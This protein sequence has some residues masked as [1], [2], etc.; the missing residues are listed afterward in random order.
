MQDTGCRIQ[1]ANP[2]CAFSGGRARSSVLGIRPS[3]L[4]RSRVPGARYP[5]PGTRYQALVFKK[6]AH[7]VC[8]M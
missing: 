5:G 8:K 7:G 3:A 2:G 6:P 1:D 4:I